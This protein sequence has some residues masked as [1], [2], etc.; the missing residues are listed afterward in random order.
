MGLRTLSLQ[1]VVV[2]GLQKVWETRGHPPGGHVM[3]DYRGIVGQVEDGNGTQRF[4]GQRGEGIDRN[5]CCALLLVCKSLRYAALLNTIY[6]LSVVF[7]EV[8]LCC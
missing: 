6:F 4:V 7:P 1:L 5:L 3:E 2:T 8:K